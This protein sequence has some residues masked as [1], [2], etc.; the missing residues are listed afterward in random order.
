MRVLVTGADG[1]VGPHLVRCLAQVGHEVIAHGG[2][3]AAEGPL[4]I[5][6]FAA[7]SAA[8]KG[9]RPDAVA[10]LAGWSSVGA[11]FERPLDCF[12]VNA[13]GTAHLL[14]A[15]R[16]EAPRARLLLISSAE[17]YGRSRAERLRRED[18]A[19]AAASPYAMS[20]QASEL[21]GLHYHATF[22]TSVVI[23]R[24]FNHVGPGQDPKFVV[25]SLLRQISDIATARATVLQVGNLDPVRDFSSVSDV[26]AAYA[27]LLESG[28][29]GQVYNVCSGRGRSIREVLDELLRKAN[30]VAE[31]RVD[32]AR[33]RSVDIPHLVG[34]PTK[35][36]ALGWR[37]QRDPFADLLP[38][39]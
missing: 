23:A 2:P 29:P 12:A 17:V 37:A 1:F 8:L 6:N 21:V 24:A 22:G 26:V 31:I 19:L 3:L 10:H 13:L 15:A 28:V 5:Q 34:D 11:S 33:V 30:V 7:V 38:P 36:A 14:E 18:D 20:K 4:D 16:T 25:P 32:P 35:L 27:L 39:S 9:S